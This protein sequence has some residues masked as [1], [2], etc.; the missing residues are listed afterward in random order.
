MTRGSHS[1][2]TSH[3]HPGSERRPTRLGN[4]LDEAQHEAARRTGACL[5]NTEWEKV[6]GARIAARTRVGTL[7]QD[8]LVVYAGSAA[9]AN[10]LTFLSDDILG[11]LRRNGLGVKK[12]RFRIRDL[13]PPTG[14]W[15]R[16]P[17]RRPAPPRAPL[18]KE[19]LKRLEQVDD[20]E[21]RKAIAEAA[22]L[23]LGAAQGVGG[24]RRGPKE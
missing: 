23:S 10:E 17:E 12:L 20:P 18:P 7:Q 13:G 3:R 6:V 24:S 2:K 8:T 5:T 22:A 9:W 1:G 4:L 15:A 11:R 21:L 14:S 16:K 19:L